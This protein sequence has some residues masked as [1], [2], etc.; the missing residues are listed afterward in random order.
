MKKT[1]EG[2]VLDKSDDEVRLADLRE[3]LEVVWNYRISSIGLTSTICFQL[4][5]QLLFFVYGFVFV[6]PLSNLF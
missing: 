3:R 5:F 4:L 2:D 6:F 1:M